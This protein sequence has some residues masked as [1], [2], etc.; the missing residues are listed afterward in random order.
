MNIYL[1][2]LIYILEIAIFKEHRKGA[3]KYMRV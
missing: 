3:H 1:L 2:G